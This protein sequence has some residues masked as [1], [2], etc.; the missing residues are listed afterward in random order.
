M[1]KGSYLISLTER[2]PTVNNTVREWDPILT[3]KLP[4][5]W[6]LTTIHVHKKL[7]LPRS[8]K[9]SIE[10][11]AAAFGIELDNEEEYEIE[12]EAEALGIDVDGKLHDLEVKLTGYAAGEQAIIQTQPSQQKSLQ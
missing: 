7:T 3:V 5:S 6:G 10:D 4:M 1:K 2:L 12:K 11:D 9:N 8:R